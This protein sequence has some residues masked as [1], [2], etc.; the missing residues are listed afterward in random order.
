MSSATTTISLVNL[1]R[2]TLFTNLPY[3]LRFII[4]RL[5]L[6][7]RVVEIIESELRTGFYSQAAPPTALHVCRESRQAVEALYPSCFGSFLQPERVRFNFDL[8]VLYLD[9]SQ[10]EEA[11]PH[12]L[13]ILKEN[14]LTR[15]KNFAI[16]ETYLNLG[17]IGPHL[18]KL[19]LQQALKAMTNLKEMIV[20]RD[21]TSRRSDYSYS[22]SLPMR[23][24]KFYAEHRIAEAEEGWPDYV[25]ELPD[26]KEKYKGWIFSD[27]I[28]MTLVYG[29]RPL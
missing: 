23:Q 29:W 19:A 25:E 12:L 26:A 10:E 14:E 16:D 1:Q 4:W 21:I 24:I 11:L 17:I 15:L 5:S 27:V 7:P 22:Y 13:G 28:N 20:V 2:F 6:S 9:I 18:A 8:D 3:E